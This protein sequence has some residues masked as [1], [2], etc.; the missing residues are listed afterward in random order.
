MISRT[1]RLLVVLVS[2]LVQPTFADDTT[3]TFNHM[4]VLGDSL[5]DQGNL[6]FATGDLAQAFDLPP[7]DR[8]AFWD[9]E[10]PTTRFHAILADQLYTA[11]LHCKAEHKG[12]DRVTSRCAVNPH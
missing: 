10:H 4:Y 3:V 5:S 9:I 1:V 7:I 11:V 8:Y 2:L 12:K 6:F